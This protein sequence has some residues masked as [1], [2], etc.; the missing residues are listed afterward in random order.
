LSTYLAYTYLDAEF[1]SDFTSCKPF[2]TGQT[3]CIPT[4]AS[5][6]EKILSGTDIPG[7]YKHTLF[8]EVAWKHQASGFSTALEARA[9]SKTFVAFK[10]AYGK[11]DGYGIFAWRGGFTQKL[12]NWKLNEFVRIENLFDKDT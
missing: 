10:S 6:V 2:A 3:T 8:G 1:S 9:N 5:H 11:A 4:T 12:S 7:T